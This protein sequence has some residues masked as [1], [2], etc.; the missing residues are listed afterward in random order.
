MSKDLKVGVYSKD[1]IFMRVPKDQIKIV[2]LNA[3]EKLKH[4]SLCLINNELVGVAMDYYEDEGCY[5]V[6]WDDRKIFAYNE[7]DSSH[8]PD[9]VGCQLYLKDD[10][11]TTEKG[12][13][14]P[15]GYFLGMKGNSVLFKLI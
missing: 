4:P 11:I 3:G 2:G 12:S 15:L 9:K 14:K 10:V 7:V 13:N 8:K 1:A 6:D 5:L